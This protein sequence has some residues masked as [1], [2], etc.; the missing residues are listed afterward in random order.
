MSP[1]ATFIPSSAL[2]SIS[3]NS[4]HLA[5]LPVVFPEDKAASMTGHGFQRLFGRRSDQTT[6]TPH[7]R[8][9]SKVLVDR[10]N[11]RRMDEEEQLD[12]HSNSL[13]FDRGFV[14]RGVRS[15]LDEEVSGFLAEA[16]RV[17]AANGCFCVRLR[18]HPASP[19]DHGGSDWRRLMPTTTVKFIG[20]RGKTCHHQRSALQR[21][22]LDFDKMQVRSRQCFIQAC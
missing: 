19:G 12:D 11:I 5:L 4:P 10:I 8:T 2:S 22:S 6:A 15:I 9:T 18:T 21:P 7:Q 16:P 13:R 3:L 1:A 17:P 20:W 14:D